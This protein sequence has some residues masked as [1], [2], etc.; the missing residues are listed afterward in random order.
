MHL[1]AEVDIELR[2]GG[3]GCH[4]GLKPQQ[5]G[6]P[7]LSQRQAIITRQAFGSAI[8]LPWM[9]DIA[10][11]VQF[12]EQLAE[13]KLVGVPAHQQAMSGQVHT[14]FGHRRQPPQALLDQPAAGRATDAFDKQR[15]L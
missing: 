10:N 12:V 11:R 7:Q 8:G 15:G 4:H 9:G 13:G 5:A 2:P 6:D 1:R 14:R 3:H